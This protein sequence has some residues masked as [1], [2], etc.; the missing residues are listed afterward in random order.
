LHWRKANG[1]IRVIFAN[2]KVRD[3]FPITDPLLEN[4]NVFTFVYPDIFIETL[5]RPIGWFKGINMTL[6]TGP[7]ACKQRINPD[8][9]ANVKNNE[10]IRDDFLKKMQRLVLKLPEI[11]ISV[12]GF[13]HIQK[14]VKPEFG[15]YPVVPERK[16]S[17]FKEPAFYNAFSYYCFY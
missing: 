14:N 16:E 11:K 9:G 6:C 12:D 7:L 3:T 5:K 10:A 1:I 15:F 4:G 17:N 8:I 13:L 2:I